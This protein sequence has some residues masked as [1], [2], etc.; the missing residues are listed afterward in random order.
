MKKRH[1]EDS[2]DEACPLKR[3]RLT[4]WHQHLKNFGQ[5]EGIE[6]VIPIYITM[7]LSAICDDYLCLGL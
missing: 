2:P 5:S 1:A 3:V 4:P 6:P 7:H